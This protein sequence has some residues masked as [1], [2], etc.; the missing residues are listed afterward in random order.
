MPRKSSPR[1][2]SAKRVAR[3]GTNI[4]STKKGVTDKVQKKI[5]EQSK[6]HGGL[7][8]LRSYDNGT[9]GA[10]FKDGQFRFVKGADAAKMRK[11][12]KKSPKDYPKRYSPRSKTSSKK[13]HSPRSAKTAMSRYYNK[14]TYAGTKKEMTSGKNIG[15]SRRNAAIKRDMCQSKNVVDDYRWGKNPERYDLKGYDDG[16]QCS[17]D[18][19]TTYKKRS[20]SAAQK[21]VLA[22]RLV[23]A[24][25][26]KSQKGGAKPVSLKTAVNLLRQYYAEKYN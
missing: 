24:R 9:I 18:K 19:K 4:T 1:K 15:R 21:K 11:I 17:D 3:K 12:G 6:E 13:T 25:A 8:E 16:S 22:K 2:K 5:D 23:S 26:K 14:K 10:F 20:V 7:N